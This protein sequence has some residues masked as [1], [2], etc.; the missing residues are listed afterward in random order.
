M[1]TIAYAQWVIIDIVNASSQ[2]IKIK[3]VVL[4]W[5]KF[6][7]DGTFIITYHVPLKF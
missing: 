7:K 2:P 3:D 4:Y 6:H 5:G 1:D